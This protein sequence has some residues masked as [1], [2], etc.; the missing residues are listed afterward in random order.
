MVAYGARIVIK[1][2]MY[3]TICMKR[4]DAYVVRWPVNLVAYF[5]VMLA[6]KTRFRRIQFHWYVW[7]CVTD[8][9]FYR[10][11]GSSKVLTEG[12]LGLYCN[13]ILPINLSTNP[14]ALC[15]SFLLHV[16]TVLKCNR[17]VA[18]CTSWRFLGNDIDGRGV[19]QWLGSGKRLGVSIGQLWLIYFT[20]YVDTRLL[21]T[22]FCD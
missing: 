17:L 9:H 5:I 20:I 8:F 14:V 10:R 12:T 7:G 15:F 6:N 16:Q 21:V 18:Q 19:L 11:D 4:M 1:Q 3:H 13:I 22:V 2:P